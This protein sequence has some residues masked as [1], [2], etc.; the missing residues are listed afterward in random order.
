MWEDTIVNEIRAARQAHAEKFGFDLPAIYDDLKQAE[1][2][3]NRR[4]VS[5]PP[6]PAMLAEP[7]PRKEAI[8]SS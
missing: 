7:L 3:S 1:E 8:K 4:I 2:R 5:F 6:K